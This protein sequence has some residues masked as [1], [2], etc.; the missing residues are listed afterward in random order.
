MN[1][2]TPIETL[3]L[4]ASPN[5]RRAL[6]REERDAQKPPLTEEAKS[7]IAKLDELI[8]QAM[9]ACKRGMT[10]GGRKNPAFANLSLLVKARKILSEAKPVPPAPKSTD[11]TLSEIDAILSEQVPS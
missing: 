3:K 7:E 6:R 2:R 5:L 8:Q 10:T 1:P 4:V 11:E 9:R